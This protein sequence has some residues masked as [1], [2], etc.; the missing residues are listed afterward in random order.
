MLAVTLVGILPGLRLE[1]ALD[2]FA[3]FEFINIAAVLFGA[4]YALAYRRYLFHDPA[5]CE[6]DFPWLAA[7]L[8]PRRLHWYL[9]HSPVAGWT[10]SIRCRALRSGPLSA[11]YSMRWP[12]RW[13]SQ[14]G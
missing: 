5:A 4:G 6:D 14:P 7:A 8:I 3:I 13:R 12:T 10:V 1:A 11:G 9:F 2:R